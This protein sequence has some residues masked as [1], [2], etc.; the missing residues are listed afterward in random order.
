MIRNGWIGVD[1]DGCL[2]FD[3]NRGPDYI[4]EPIPQML[5]RVKDWISIGVEVRIFTARCS[6]PEQLAPVQDWLDKHGIG[7][8][9]ITNVKDY[10][11]IQ[12]WDDR[13]VQVIHNTGK[14]VK[15]WLDE[16]N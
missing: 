3:E 10:G 12:L 11:L 2:A 7:E 5:K 9:K 8:L 15:Q 13:A 1:L 14:T 4:G 6:V 16:R